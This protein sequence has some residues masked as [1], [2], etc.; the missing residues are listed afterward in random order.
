MELLL[1]EEGDPVSLLPGT[2]KMI[3]HDVVC[4]IADYL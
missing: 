3:V 1:E 2:I 4:P